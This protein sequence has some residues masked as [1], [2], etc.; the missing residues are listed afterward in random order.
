MRWSAI[1]HE[2]L[3]VQNIPKTRKKQ[4][5]LVLQV[6]RCRVT[7]LLP[8]PRGVTAPIEHKITSQQLRRHAGACTMKEKMYSTSVR[9]KNGELIRSAP[10]ANAG[11]STPTPLP[12]VAM[13]EN[14]RMTRS[15]LPVQREVVWKW[16]RTVRG[17][18]C[19]AED[20]GKTFSRSWRA[21]GGEGEA[22]LAKLS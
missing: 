18:R 22:R 14:P 4:E 2:Q 16:E 12:P 19:A 15:C 3:N 20:F 5:S 1:A 13:H 17:R 10:R 11:K 21:G 9:I 8:P 6:P 7:H